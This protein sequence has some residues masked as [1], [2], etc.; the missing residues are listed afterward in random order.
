MYL[1][2]SHFFITPRGKFVFFF[3]ICIEKYVFIAKKEN[4]DVCGCFYFT[5]Q[6]NIDIPYLLLSYYF[7]TFFGNYRVND[8]Y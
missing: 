1:N 6:G 5:G 2:E 3:L 7:F 8:F 4:I